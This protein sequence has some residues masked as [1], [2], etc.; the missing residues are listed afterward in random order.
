MGL[1]QN[2]RQLKQGE[3]KSLF[4]SCIALWLWMLPKS[5]IVERW[6]NEIWI[7]YLSIGA[8]W[9]ASS[10]FCFYCRFAPS[11]FHRKW[12]NAAV[13]VVR[14]TY[15][16]KD[17]PVLSLF[18]LLSCSSFAPRAHNQLLILVGDITSGFITRP[19]TNTAAQTP[20]FTG[21]IPSLIRMAPLSGALYP[22]G[23]GQHNPLTYHFPVC[24]FCL[25][26]CVL[27]QLHTCVTS[28]QPVSKCR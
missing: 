10:I 8:A 22:G 13:F 26:S 24:S 19:S 21:T 25:L 16:C 28:K 7:V 17:S 15:F 20:W 1:I 6:Q 14:V 4:L 5:C 12:M 3:L 18:R 11:L 9:S 27:T 23:P 2:A